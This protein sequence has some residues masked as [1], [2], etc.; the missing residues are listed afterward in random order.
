M[1]FLKT[2]LNGEQHGFTSLSTGTEYL[3]PEKKLQV[4]GRK[5]KRSG[6][7]T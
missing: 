2:S 6:S 4:L 1:D 3:Q 5:R 7:E